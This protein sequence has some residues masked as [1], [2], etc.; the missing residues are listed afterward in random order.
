MRFQ[1]CLF[2]LSAASALAAALPAEPASHEQAKRVDVFIETPP[3]PSQEDAKLTE[4][5]IV[6]QYKK[7]KGIIT[8]GKREDHE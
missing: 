2:L 1:S 3:P 5:E 4:A 8:F 6:A 7:N